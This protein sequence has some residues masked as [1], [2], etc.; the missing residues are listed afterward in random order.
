MGFEEAVFQ[1]SEAEMIRAALDY[2]G[3]PDLRESTYEALIQKQYIKADVKPLFPGRL[4]TP[5]GKIE[6]YSRRME[7]HG[8]PPLPLIFR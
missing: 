6:L 3:N 4:K 7:R 8:H 1:E 5:S 2:P